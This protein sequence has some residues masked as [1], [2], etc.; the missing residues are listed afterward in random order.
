MTC[1][2]CDGELLMDRMVADDDTFLPPYVPRK[3]VTSYPA[4]VFQYACPFRGCGYEECIVRGQNGI[5]QWARRW[6]QGKET[7]VAPP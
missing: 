2:V 3:S 7:E 6:P 4:T 5:T 1:P